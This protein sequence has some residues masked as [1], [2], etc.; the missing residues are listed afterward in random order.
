MEQVLK[1]YG[2]GI[3][4]AVVALL[5]FGMLFFSVSD[6]D[7]NRGILKM[8]GA[9]IKTDGTCYTAFVD[10]TKLQ[11]EAWKPE[12]VLTETFAGSVLK[13][14]CDYS[15]SD[16]IQA[17][18]AAGKEYPVRLEKIQNENGEEMDSPELI[19][20]G[21]LNFPKSGIYMVQVMTENDA[22]KK[23]RYQIAV[24]VTRAVG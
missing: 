11:E 14:G 13:A 19:K 22:G 17:I 18:D 7:G 1:H 6:A 10:F 20:N 15:I 12:P 16:Y 5:L 21:I 24:A 3:L 9:R 23:K 4:A 8:A 2:S